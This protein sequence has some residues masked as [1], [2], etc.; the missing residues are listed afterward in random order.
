MRDADREHAELQSALKA[1]AAKL[2]AMGAVGDESNA[3][4]VNALINLKG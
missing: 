3:G 2:A 4:L 1:S